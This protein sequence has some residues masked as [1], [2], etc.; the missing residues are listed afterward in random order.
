VI[1]NYA[2]YGNNILI[3]PR[4]WESKAILRYIANKHGLEAWYPSD[5]KQRA[6]CDLALDFHSTCFMPVVGGKILF[7]SVGFGTVTAEEV[8][9]AEK[10]WN[11]D[12]W[13]TFQHLNQQVDGPLLGGSKPNIADLAFL[14]FL[15]MLFGKCPSS[16]AG[17]SEGLRSYLEAL[18]ASL[19]KYSE[20]MKDAE[21]TWK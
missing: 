8:A 13:P 11:E 18:K 4:R 15:V 21:A 20:Y 10:K 16:F 17:K 7:P 6:L 14:G 12:V 9:E 2:L 1:S 5:P 3:F 19:P